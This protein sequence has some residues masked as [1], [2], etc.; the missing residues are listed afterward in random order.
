MTDEELGREVLTG[1]SI[2]TDTEYCARVGAR[3]RALLTK[4]V[5]TREELCRWIAKQ[6]YGQLVQPDR[7]DMILAVLQQFAAPDRPKMMIEGMTVDDIR[8]EIRRDSEWQ[9]VGESTSYVAARVA[10]RLA[11]TPAPVVDED[12]EAKRCLWAW[13]KATH[14]NL[15]DSCHSP[16]ELWDAYGEDG[17]VGWRAVAKEVGG[18]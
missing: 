8:D 7:I 4:P 13:S 9:S 18:E 17:R 5:A 10:H 1:F 12:A 11:N 3:V 14:S 2:G 6:Y 15:L 16:D